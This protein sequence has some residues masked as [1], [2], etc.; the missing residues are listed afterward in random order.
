VDGKDPDT[1]YVKEKNEKDSQGALI[2]AVALSVLGFIFIVFCI[3]Y[4]FLKKYQER[5]DVERK[6]ERTRDEKNKPQEMNQI[7]E[8]KNFDTVAKFN[9]FEQQYDPN[10]D[11]AIFGVGDP[12][13]GGIQDMQ[14]K[15]NLADK[16][17]VDSDSSE[18][19]EEPRASARL[20]P[21]VLESKGSKGSDESTGNEGSHQ[22]LVSNQ[23]PEDKEIYSDDEK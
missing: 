21:T 6:I 20:S 11:F 23:L 4:F 19:E 13:R 15:M 8:D 5:L 16:P 7:S 9:E 3:R 10:N 22:K 1:K 18:E 14:E 2:A 17:R 12:T